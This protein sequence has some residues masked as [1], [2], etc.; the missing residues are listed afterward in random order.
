M[1]SEFKCGC[2]MSAHQG[3]VRVCEDHTPEKSKAPSGGEG[4][5]YNPA[6]FKLPKVI[7]RYPA[8]G[9]MVRNWTGR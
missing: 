3:L 9:M 1:F 7:K 2:I 4:R 8:N 6:G 5:L